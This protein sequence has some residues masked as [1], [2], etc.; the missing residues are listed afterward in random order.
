MPL[1]D[2]LLTKLEGA[3]AATDKQLVQ[4]Q[5]HHL[6]YKYRDASG[7]LK[8]RIENTYER[9]SYLATRVPATY[10]VCEQVF[11]RLAEYDLEFSSLLDLGSGP[12][13]AAICAKYIFPELE[14]L[15]LI[16]QDKAF[17]VFAESFLELAKPIYHLQDLTQ[18]STFP[19]HDLVTL[20]YAL[21]ELSDKKAS[22][23]VHKAWLATKSALVIV[24]PG[25]PKAFK[26][27]KTLREELI[28]YGAHILAPCPHNTTCPM[29]EDDWCHFSVRLERTSLHQYIK[30]ASLNYE[31]EKFCYVI[32]M[33]NK[34]LQPAPARLIKKPRKR[35]G[36]ILFDLCTP[37]GLQ[38]ET[39]S[40][41]DKTIYKVAQKLTWGDD[42]PLKGT[43]K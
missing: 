12:G 23:V 2:S 3:F 39:L 38:Q 7:S 8:R 29:D 13:T 21:N 33:K 16:D 5:R 9:L 11:G 31:D 25:T 14:K 34:D 35:P 10:A 42:F 24:E 40:K 30:Q 37:N 4:N 20:S 28:N 19:P 26:G 43:T 18:V 15:T 22:S 17:K 1:P 27:L 32:A 6:T 36:H 41:K